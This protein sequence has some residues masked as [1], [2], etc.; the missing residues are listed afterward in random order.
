MR[1]VRRERVPF[2]LWLSLA[3]LSEWWQF[4]RVAHTPIIDLIVAGDANGAR[5]AMREHFVVTGEMLLTKLDSI[6]F[7]DGDGAVR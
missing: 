5:D 6:S 2:G 7:W 3:Q 4:N 1:A